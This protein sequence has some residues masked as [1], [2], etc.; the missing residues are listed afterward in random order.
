MRV[1]LALPGSLS[2]A[3]ELELLR[4]GHR[5]AWRADDRESLLAQLAE[6]VPDVVLVADDPAVATTEVVGA[7]DL[8]GVR[9]CLVRADDAVSATARLLGVHDILRVLP[10][11]PIDLRV[12]A[13]P[14]DALDGGIADAAGAHPGFAGA[15]PSSAP[16]API[17][18]A[19]D[20]PPPAAPPATGSAPPPALLPPHRIDPSASPT[21]ADGRPRRTPR[22]PGAS[23]RWPWSRDRDTRA[24]ATPAA[25]EPAGAHASTPPAA[26]SSSASTL[27]PPDSSAPSEKPAAERAVPL[28]T[29]P[30]Q[31]IVAVWGPAG[32]PGRTTLAIALAA[33]L[34]A[35]GLR[36][37]LVDADTYGGTV[38]PALGLLDEAPGFAA[39]CR[40]AGSGALT[41][42]ELD[43]IALTYGGTAAPFR[44]LTGIGRPHRW[45]ELSRDRVAR[46]LEAARGWSD[47]V[48]VDTGFNLETD[49]EVSSDMLAP[50]RNAA[51]IAA[52]RAA[53][54]V[55][56]VGAADPVGLARLLRTH[57][58]LLETVTTDRVHV[59]A[60]RI[61][62]SVLGIDP[63][64]QVRQTLDRFGGI[65]DPIL[66]ADDPSAADA[67]LLS[68][69]TVLDVAPRSALRQGAAALADRLGYGAAA[70]RG[71]GAASSRGRG[72]LR[73]TG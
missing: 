12:L 32:A 16:A 39:A 26:P 52:L 46:A 35:R 50:R 64:G 48:V 60:N 24:D 69:R 55:V 8:L 9:T 10:G 57:A 20:A 23:R 38:A 33:E 30:A 14:F 5:I 3:V 42:G 53:D 51:T 44:V 63:G 45:P 36:V 27:S 58:D 6:V 68:A 29:P 65:A 49:E 18:A 61:R 21:E 40:L 43:R 73:R 4:A 2:D 47:V 67:A 70:S 15:P 34:A 22:Q 25:A 71:R 1:A 13:P 19:T 31:R 7:C 62:A 66:I 37:C 59:V 17:A 11:L 72:M 56:A 54:E 28:A 41:E